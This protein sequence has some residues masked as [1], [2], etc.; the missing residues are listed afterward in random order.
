MM[1]ARTQT[2]QDKTVCIAC[3]GEQILVCLHQHGMNRD[4]PEPV[5]ARDDSDR[6]ARQEWA[7][8]KILRCSPF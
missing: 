4:E 2:V 8:V 3:V 6:K 5:A 7:F 1:D